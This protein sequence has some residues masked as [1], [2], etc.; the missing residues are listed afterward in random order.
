[1]DVAALGQH[2]ADLDVPLGG[3]LDDGR[4]DGLR[5]G[6]GE[7][8]RGVGDD[9]R[10]RAQLQHGLVLPARHVGDDLQEVQRAQGVLEREHRQPPPALLRRL[11]L[12]RPRRH[13]QL[14]QQSGPV[15]GGL[16]RRH[17]QVARGA[18]RLALGEQRQEGLDVAQHRG[19]EQRR[20]VAL[21]LDA[22]VGAGGRQQLAALGAVEQRGLH[23]RREAVGLQQV[24]A[25]GQRLERQQPLQRLDLVRQHAG[26][27]QPQ[28]VLLVRQGV[29]GQ[30]QQQQLRGGVVGVRQRHEQGEGGGVEGGGGERLQRQ[31]LQGKRGELAVCRERRRE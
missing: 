1:M 5:L 31:L 13:L 30:R 14:Q 11:V 22:P 8:E 29:R 18:A 27:Q 23:Q 17:E 15:V 21:R 26:R 3:G 10:Q 6:H 19:L 28:H 7:D 12:P 2:A 9:A 25:G 16:L 24:Q 4:L 20:L